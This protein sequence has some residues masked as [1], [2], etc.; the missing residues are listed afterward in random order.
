MERSLCLRGRN[1]LARC[2]LNGLESGN[3]RYKPKIISGC[4]TLNGNENI[5]EWDGDKW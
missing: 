4:T 1:A 2:T 3:G 5:I